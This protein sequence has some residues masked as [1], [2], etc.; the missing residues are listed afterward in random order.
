M[1][2]AAVLVLTLT[3]GLVSGDRAMAD[4]GKP[5]RA[6]YREYKQLWRKADRFFGMDGQPPPGFRRMQGGDFGS[7]H[8]DRGDGMPTTISA[9]PWVL[10]NLAGKNPDNPGG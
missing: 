4:T 1:R 7:M 8:T 9:K 6:A 10:R 3:I 2:V 5:G